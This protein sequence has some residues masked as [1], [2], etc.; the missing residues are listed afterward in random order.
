MRRLRGLAAPQHQLKGSLIIC[1]QAKAAS[2]AGSSSSSS[3]RLARAVRAV[4]LKVITV[5]KGSSAA[6]EAMADEW[7]AKVARYTQA[8]HVRLKPNPKK[9]ASPEVAMKYEGA[10]VLDSLAPGELLIVMDERG[11]EMTSEGFADLIAHAGD[12]GASGLAFAIGGP[13]GHDEE[14][15]R[16]ASRVI[17]LSACVLNHQVA[18]VVLLEQLYR[19]W[20]I[21]RGE[22]YHH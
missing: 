19:G 20:T 8:T 15:R 7:R 17:R 1:A 4:P 11:K 2:T 14:V 13:Y 3:Q 22:P 16:K 18:H 6:A 12:N 10:R 5:S 9:A 21:L